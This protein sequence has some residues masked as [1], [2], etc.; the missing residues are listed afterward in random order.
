MDYKK[1][2]YFL[3]GMQRIEHTFTDLESIPQPVCRV[4]MPAVF[5]SSVNLVRSGLCVVA[6]HMIRIA[7][8]I[9]PNQHLKDLLVSKW[10]L[11]SLNKNKPNNIFYRGKKVT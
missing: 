4:L 8:A 11:N 3:S 9:S 2:Y 10:S 6:R 1:D 5:D 7:D